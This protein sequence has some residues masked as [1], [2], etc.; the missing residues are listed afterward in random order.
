MLWIVEGFPHDGALF[1]VDKE[2]A[3]F[4]FRDDMAE[5][6]GGVQNG[7]VVEAGFFIMVSKIEMSSGAA[8]GFGFIEIA[9]VAVN[10]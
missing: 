3:I 6:T 7:T 4:G 10:F 1:E 2:G 9:R 8:G 5:D